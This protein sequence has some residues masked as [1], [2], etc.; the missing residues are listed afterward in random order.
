VSHSS[1]PVSHDACELHVE[2]VRFLGEQ[3]GAP[4]RLLKRQLIEFFMIHSGIQRAYLAQIGAGEHSGVALCI[5]NIGGPD[6]N[7]A[8]KIGAIFATIF[9]SRMSLDILFLS[10]VQESSLSSV[11]SP[12]FSTDR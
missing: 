6:R 8:Q 4:E 5:R 3:D 11:C 9:N 12:F 10:D 7:L 1:K 2:N